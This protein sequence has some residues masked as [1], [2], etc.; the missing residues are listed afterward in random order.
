MKNFLVLSQAVSETFFSIIDISTAKNSKD[1]RELKYGHR[2]YIN[3]ITNKSMSIIDMFALL[4][5]MDP[6][7]DEYFMDSPVVPLI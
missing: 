3:T 7:L 5:Y 1:I 4:C 6:Y 2:L